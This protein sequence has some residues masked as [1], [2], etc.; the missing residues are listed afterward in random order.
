MLM[1]LTPGV[2]FT[3]IYKQLLCVKIKKAQEDTDDLTFYFV[4]LGSLRIK[5][6][7]KHVGEINHWH[8]FHQHTTHDFF[9]QK[10]CTQFFSNYSLAM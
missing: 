6:A 1:K 9:V 7:P 2:D 3:N 4:L 10:C 5:A 8:Q